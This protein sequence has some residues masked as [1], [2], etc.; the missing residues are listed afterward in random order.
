MCIGVVTALPTLTGW[1]YLP[2][3]EVLMGVVVYWDVEMTDAVRIDF[4]EQ[5]TWEE[6]DSAVDDTYRL[7]CS[8]PQVVDLLINFVST[9]VPSED[10]LDMRTEHFLRSM[11][12]N[13]G[14]I[15][16]INGGLANHMVLP[17]FIRPFSRLISITS[18]AATLEIAKGVLRNQRTLR[19]LDVP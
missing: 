13:V 10:F 5:W 18:A 8:V 1:V 9:L 16:V 7:M 6:F 3:C 4:S 11:P 19:G 15:V 17:V 14:H 2:R 12:D